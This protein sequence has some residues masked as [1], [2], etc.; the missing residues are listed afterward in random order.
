MTD[1]PAKPLKAYAVLETEEGTGGIIFARRDIEARKRGSCEYSDGD[2]SSVTC[3]RA[4]WAD[5]YA[6]TKR[7]PVRAAIEHG[8]RFEC[9]GCAETLSE[10][11]FYDEDKPIEGVIGFMDSLVFCCAECRD[12]HKEVERRKKA[13]GQEFLDVMRALVTKRFGP[14]EFCEDGFKAH[15]YVTEQDGALSVGQAA[16]SF[17]FPG[18]VIAPATLRYEW[19]Y[20][21]AWDGIGCIKPYFTCRNGDRDAF[22]AFAAATKK[23][24]TDARPS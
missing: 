18:Q 5:E 3:R 19:P 20:S 15:V 2:I 17:H 1:A 8:W 6:E 4:P 14:V 7:I 12:A 23:D 10:D 13:F 21:F 11:R 9:H 22:E 16:I 24:L